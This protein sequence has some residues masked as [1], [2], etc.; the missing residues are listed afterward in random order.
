MHNEDIFLVGDEGGLVPMATQPFDSESYLQELLERYPDLLPG[1]QIAPRSPRKWL[2]IAREMGVPAEEGGTAQWSLDHLFVDQD[3][4]P[5]IVEVKRSTD[6][7]IRRE[8][9]GQ[10]LD[11]AA[12][13]VRYWPADA[14]RT[15]LAL[16]LGGSDLADQQVEALTDEQSSAEAFWQRAAEH[17]RA[18]KI[19]IIFAA[20]SI[21]TQLRGVIE[22]LN[23]QMAP[24]EVLGVEV[25]QYEGQGNRM[26]V[27]TVVGATAT[28]TQAKGAHPTK[29]VQERFA[30]ASTATREIDERLRQWAQH[31]GHRHTTSNAAR[32]FLL[33]DERVAFLHVYPGYESLEVNVQLLRDRGKPDKADEIQQTLEDMAGRSLASKYPGIKATDLQPQVEHFVSEVLD[34]YAAIMLGHE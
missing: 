20:D 32:K 10:A 15:Q 7:R 1:G 8:V 9:I 24:A 3:A 31:Q 6:S 34:R 12:N 33:G 30:D 26:L 11:Y 19:R 23:E 16:R 28:A 4:V 5:T 21:P 14:L 18:G 25:K 27:P 17:L 22:F 2:L 13:G 29:S